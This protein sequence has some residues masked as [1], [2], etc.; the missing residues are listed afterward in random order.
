ML[1]GLELKL[2]KLVTLIEDKNFLTSQV[3]ARILSDLRSSI[4][5]VKW[6]PGALDFTIFDD[7]GRGHG[8]GNGV[9][10]IKKLFQSNLKEKGWILEKKLGITQY[11]T[12]G[13]IDAMLQVGE[14]YFAVEWETG[15]ISSSHRALN[16]MSIGLLH[17]KLI[18]GILIMPTRNMYCYLTDRVGNFAEIEP[19]LDLWKSLNIKS[20]FLGIIVVEQDRVSKNVPRIPKGT[21]GRALR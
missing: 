16:K 11:K 18:G 6:P 7:K 4:D 21:D 13:K 2:V 5:N 10:P 12:P 15:N 9:T 1:Q 14:K 17:D 3:W 8:R 20:G 19:Y